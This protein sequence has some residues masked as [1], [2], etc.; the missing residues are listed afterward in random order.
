MAIA[1]ASGHP[2]ICFGARMAAEKAGLCFGMITSDRIDFFLAARSCLEDESIKAS[3]SA[4]K[5]EDLN[6]ISGGNITGQH[7]GECIRII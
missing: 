1:V 5:S 2:Q 3:I 7:V 4:L 6:A